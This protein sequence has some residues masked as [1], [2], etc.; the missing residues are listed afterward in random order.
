MDIVDKL[1]EFSSNRQDIHL[2]ESLFKE[3]LRKWGI[4]KK[5]ADLLFKWGEYGYNW[6]KLWENEEE[7]NMTSSKMLD[8]FYSEVEYCSD[9]MSYDRLFRCH[10]LYNHY[11]LK[12]KEGK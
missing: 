8:K 4:S 12:I 11:N 10:W 5:S 2:W 9:R 7:K 6:E 3:V 1:C